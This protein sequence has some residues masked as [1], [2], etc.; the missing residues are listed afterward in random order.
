M[1]CLFLASQAALDVLLPI[2][3]L[4]ALYRLIDLAAE[5]SQHIMQQRV[6]ESSSNG[7]STN[8]GIAAALRRRSTLAALVLLAL[9]A[10]AMFVLP[11]LC[12]AYVLRSCLHM[13]DLVLHQ[14]RPHL[15]RAVGMLAGQASAQLVPLDAALQVRRGY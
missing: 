13:A 8:G 2:L 7:S 12:C 14:Y 6:A 3:G 9:R 15:P 5:R 10:P 11:P 4:L 1:F